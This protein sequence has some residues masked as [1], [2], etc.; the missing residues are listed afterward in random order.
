MEAAGI[1]VIFFFSGVSEEGGV[2]EGG[3]VFDGY[4]EE[5]LQEFAQGLP[6]DGVSRHHRVVSWVSRRYMI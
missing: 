1:Q 5:L 4:G 2:L 6:V 3:G